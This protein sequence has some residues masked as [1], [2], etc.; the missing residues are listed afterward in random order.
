MIF[1]GVLIDFNIVS[2]SVVVSGAPI[3]AGVGDVFHVCEGF[4][5]E[6]IVYQSHSK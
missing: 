1:L 4:F 6:T 3:M 5:H 2:S